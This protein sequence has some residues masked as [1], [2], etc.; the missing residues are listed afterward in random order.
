MMNVAPVDMHSTTERSDS[1]SSRMSRWGRLAA[2]LIPL[3]VLWLIVL[4][5]TA[6]QPE[7]ARQ[8]ERLDRQGIDPSAMYYTELEVM[9]P[10]LHKL[11]QRE[12]SHE[13]SFWRARI[14]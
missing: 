5:W 10:I 14:R 13:Y 6:A 9:R 2:W 12:R 8:L 3:S 11:N 7:M 1:L 4:P